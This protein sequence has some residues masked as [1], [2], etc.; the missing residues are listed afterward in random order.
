MLVCFSLTLPSPTVLATPIAIPEVGL[1]RSICQTL[2]VSR[3]NLTQE[4]VAE[5][6]VTLEAS[7]LDIRDLT[8]LEFA[9]NLEILVL[10]DNLIDD[11][12]PISSLAKLRKLDLS[13]NKLR[14]IG[15][16]VPLS[17]SMM[18]KRSR[19]CN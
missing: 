2:G 9:R 11:I 7:S 6:L 14:S 5:K 1:E 16:L 10:R 18:R 12:G 4:L 13:G 19:I 3:E 17:G 15:G 8:G